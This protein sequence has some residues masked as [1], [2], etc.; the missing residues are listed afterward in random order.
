MSSTGKEKP[1]KLIASFAVRAVVLICREE[2]ESDVQLCLPACRSYFT[3]SISRSPNL[4]EPRFQGSIESQG[5]I[6]APAGHG[7]HPILFLVGRG[8][9]TKVNTHR[10]VGN[11][12]DALVLAVYPQQWWSF[13]GQ[14]DRSATSKL[15]LQYFA[16][17]FLGDG[18]SVGM[19][20]NILVD[21]EASSGQKL[22]FPVGLGFG[23]V[24]KICG[25]PVKFGI[26]GQ[27]MAIQP[28]SS[29]QKWNVEFS[30]VPRIANPIS[31]TLFD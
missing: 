6:V 5:D 7:L 20:P 8:F 15:Q 23:K 14:S 30:I 10:A 17:Y 9:G 11:D 1:E 3:S 26:E 2:A 27:Y 12:L 31:G 19:S 24:V 25:V 18:W 13:A 4:V 28:D 29:G 16:Q 22:T 21:W